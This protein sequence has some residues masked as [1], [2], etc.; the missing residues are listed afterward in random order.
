MQT[1]FLYKDLLN[2][3]VGVLLIVM[4][5]FLYMRN[6]ISLSIFILMAGALVLRLFIIKLDPFLYVWDEEFHALV[7]K[8]MMTNPF[9]PML[10]ANPLP[11]YNSDSWVSSHIWLHKGPVFLWLITISFKI[12]GMNE[13]ALRI[14]S[15]LLTALMIPL[16]FRIGKLLVSE[17]VGYYTSFLFATANYQLEMVTGIIPSDHND[18]VFILFICA[19]FWAWFEFQN[20]GKRYWIFLIGLF[21]G[22]AVDTKWVMGFLV[23]FCWLL[24]IISNKEKRNQ[25]GSYRALSKGILI[26]IVIGMPW[27]IYAFIRF[28][29]EM[30]ATLKSYS[31]HLTKIVESHSGNG[32]YH[33]NLLGEQYG[34]VV[35]FIILPSLYFL[36]K[37]IEKKSDFKIILIAWLLFVEI[38]YSIA[39]TKM[40]L[41]TIIVAPIIYLA[42]GNFM[43]LGVD[44]LIIRIGKYKAILVFLIFLIIGFLNININEIEGHHTDVGLMVSQREEY[45]HNATIFKNIAIEL[46]KKDYVLFNCKDAIRAMFYTGMTAYQD[47][48]DDSVCGKLKKQGTKLAVFNDGKLP[49]YVLDDPEIL[50][51][52]YAV[53]PLY[54]CTNQDINIEGSEKK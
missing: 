22:L 47:I 6:R 25:F 43:L 51:L 4:S 42:L 21:S 32:F 39:C 16:L 41:F 15:I 37:A 9:K 44:W 26:S 49:K 12:F 28:P 34:W 45:M 29:S 48:P 18:V 33:L 8:N 3:N 52:N 54:I 23:F 36:Y 20:S 1:H 2:L 30:S 53:I 14:P 31:D 5:V 27:Y 40:P 7:A 13:V 10:Y 50:K 17:K 35:P 24:T 46:P 19:S 38:F 11:Y